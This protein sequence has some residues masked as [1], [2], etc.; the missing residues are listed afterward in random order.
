MSKPPTKHVIILGSG[1]AGIEVLKRLQGKF[2]PKDN[3]EVTLVSRDNFLLF[4]PMLPEVSTGRIETHHIVTPVRTFINNN[5]NRNNKHFMFH[6]ANI[7][8]IDLHNN[9]IIISHD[10]GTQSTVVIKDYNLDGKEIQGQQLLNRQ[11]QP[12]QEQIQRHLHSLQYDFLVIALG[13]ETNFFGLEDMK[14][15]ALTMKDIDDAIVLRNHILEMLEQADLEY[16][17]TEL[18]RSFLTFVVVGGGFNGIETVGE[19]NDFVRET[20]REYYKNI[21]MTDIRVVVVNAGDK[22]L[23][24][25]DE[26][27]GRW[28]LQKLKSKG[29]EFIMNT[30]ATGATADSIKLDNGETI[31]THTIVWSAGVT[32]SKIVAE[33][34]CEHDKHHRIISNSH[35]EV[36][37]YEDKVY[38]LGDCASITDPNTGKPYPPTAQHA[39]REARVVVDNLISQIKGEKK[40]EK[41]RFDFKTKGM[42]A[43]IGKRTGVATLFG[44][45][46]KLHGFIA[47]WFWRTFYL[48]NLPTKKKKIKVVSDWTMDLFFK[49]DV[50]MIK[51]ADLNKKS[52]ITDK[53]KRREGLE[54]EVKNRH[55][56]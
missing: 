46:I 22:I 7:E 41:K 42:M 44:G 36:S 49:P 9:E 40:V 28:A 31:S 19:L 56:N 32:P 50:A 11:L 37:G 48:S 54:Q 27:L 38:A 35:L 55:A 33:L 47:W 8:V 45:R 3:I 2:T 23:E 6:Q 21:Y 12:E 17:N 18:R 34:E 15:Y 43:E 14:K 24:Q 39:L 51:R 25:V 16:S 52:G 10:I 29:V 20:V 26:D 30:Q 5:N 53:K 13:S 1:F 4:T